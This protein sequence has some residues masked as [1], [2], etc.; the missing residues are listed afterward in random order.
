MVLGILRIETWFGR[1]Y[2]SYN[3]FP[4]LLH[5]LRIGAKR[6]QWVQD[7]VAALIMY[8]RTKGCNPNTLR[9]SSRGAIG[10]SQFL[11]SNYWL[12]AVDADGDDGVD[13]FTH[14][15]A[16]VSIARFLV[17]RGL[18]ISNDTRQRHRNAVWRYNPSYTHY[19]DPVFKY[20]DA[21]KKLLPK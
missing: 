19:V 7:E 11:P 14:P 20:A 15:D 10:Y 1:C 4:A 2:G 6:E 16:I 3:A 8:C 18:W 5:T 17:E 9:S 12:F 13:L 21:I